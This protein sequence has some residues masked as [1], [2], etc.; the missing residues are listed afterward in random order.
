MKNEEEERSKMCKKQRK[1]KGN[2]KRK[3]VLCVNTN[4]IK[5]VNI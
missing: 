1:N 2:I 4:Q 5:A 3:H